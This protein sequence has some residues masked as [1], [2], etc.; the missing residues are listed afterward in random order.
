MNTA[1]FSGAGISGDEPAALPRGFGLR[2]GVLETMH[3]AARCALGPLVTDDQLHNMRGAAYKLEVV[4]GRLWSV[5]G[6]DAL[7]CVL[8]LRMFVPNEAHMLSALHLLRGGTHVTVNFD[9][10]IELAYDLICGNTDLPPGAPRDYHVALPLWRTAAPPSPPALRTVSSHEEFA[11]WLREGQPAA[12]LKVHGGLTGEQKALAD[13]VVVDTEELGQLTLE[14]AAA[15]DGLGE[16]DRLLITGYSGGDP[17]VYGPLLTAAARTSATWSCLE[18]PADST[19]PTDARER[20]IDLELGRP[21]GLAV[22]ALRRLLGAPALPPWPS[23]P[24]PGDGFAERF[25]RWRRNLCAAHPADVIAQSWAWL[26]ADLGDLDI[27]VAMF[28][29]LPANVPGVRLRHAEILYNR[30]RGSDRDQAAVMFR[31]MA[32]DAGDAPTRLHCLL[33]LGDLARGRAFRRARG[34]LVV[35]HLAESYFRAVQ[36]LIA[37]RGGRRQ[38]EEGGDAYRLLQQTSLRLLEQ[39]AALAPRTSWPV[40]AVLCRLAARMGGRA[41]RLVRNGNRLSLIRQHRAML[42]A[43]AAILQG[44]SAPEDVRSDMRALRAT[45]R[46]ADDLPGAANCTVTLAVLACADGDRPGAKALLGE[47]LAEYSAGRPDGRPLPAG[48]AL[49]KVMTQLLGRL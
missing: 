27:A 19:V 37:T 33:R 45:Y 28:E 23:V 25:A 34:V 16:A 31:A 38:Q 8:A 20:G 46:A 29:A 48:E 6:P 43:L 32:T 13:V 36:V 2:D 5:V 47:A 30:A 22:T 14:R 41:A 10:G 9:V 21:R 42:R 24:L 3:Q 49:V 17:D 40:I 12:L 11:A 18:L 39:L 26:L 35:P 44:R 15:V 7:E 1:V 4:L